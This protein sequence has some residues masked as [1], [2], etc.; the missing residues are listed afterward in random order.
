MY[1]I[2]IQRNVSHG[3][4]AQKIKTVCLIS[5]LTS[6]R[7]SQNMMKSNNYSKLNLL[8]SKYGMLNTNIINSRDIN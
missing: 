4:L 3:I 5:C 2:Q 8:S 7:F 1:C 6:N